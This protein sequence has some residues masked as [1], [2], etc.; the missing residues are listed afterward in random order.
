M[1]RLNLNH[2]FYFYIV[3]KE[4][5]VKGASEKLHVT[6]PTI[7]DQLKL[8][9]EFLNTK[10]FDR[11]HRSLQ[12]NR[13]GEVVLEYA[14][15]IFDLSNDLTARIRDRLD[16]PKKTFD[17]GITYK[18]SHHFLYEL[19]LP[20]FEMSDLA[21]NVIEGERHHLLADLEN[22]SVDIVFS[23]EKEIGNNKLTS[24]KVGENKAFAVGDKKF[25]KRITDFPAD[26]SELPYFA[27]S[28]ESPFRFDIDMFFNRAGINI[29]SIGE[30]DDIDLH[31]MVV[32]KGLGF[33]IV[34]EVAANRF[35]MHKNVKIL[36]E[37]EELS[38]IVWGIV[39][40]GY[41]GLGHQLL[42]RKL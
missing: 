28:K 38:T 30:A 14:N 11:K 4:G 17:I 31:Q 29:R 37:I 3:A 35:L 21:I 19:F 6:Q 34:P 23:S 15:K 5:S 36:G 25:L 39:K 12:L 18:M 40:S 42:K 10:L 24:Y 8:L 1:E 2:L 16:L 13:D 20:L 41:R 33:S 9:E 26:L 32:N 22:G 7:S 27:F